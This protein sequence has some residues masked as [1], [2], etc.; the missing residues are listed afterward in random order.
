MATMIDRYVWAVVRLLP[1]AQRDEVDRELRSHIGEMVD[2]RLSDGADPNDPNDPADGVDGT[3]GSDTAGTD[4]EGDVDRASAAERAA[5]VDLGDPARLAVGYA[6][7][8][9]GLIA[10]ENFPQYM[11]SLRTIGI[12]AVP[13][14]TALATLGAALERDA[15]LGSVV[16]AA[17]SGA[18][19]SVVQVAFWVTLV[20]AFADRWRTPW[21]I[22]DLPEPPEHTASSAAVGMGE[23]I[24]G[25]VFTIFAGIALV[26]QHVDPP[27][28][29][30][31]G[32][33]VPVL[34]PGLWDGSA[35]ALLA[36]L[37]AS[38]AVQVVVLAS[39]RW[40]T[41]LAWMN[42]GVNAAFL[43]VVA[44]AALDE[45]LLNPRFFELLLEE[46]HTE[47]LITVSPWVP[48]VVVGA[49][50]VWDA[51]EAFWRARP[52]SAPVPTLV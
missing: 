47:T 15:D 25:V 3:Q 14:I 4:R 23:G 48:I 34:H 35:Q 8:P 28:D 36:I 11:R 2:A 46:G 39:R 21:S 51:A 50:E 42:A 33:G 20:W 9:R 10:P 44:W 38:V 19:S 24:F 31:A 18:F 27:M 52:R 22:D 13:A 40:T 26:W 29:D 32:R 45:R 17:I 37:A 12:I 7:E 43:A 6:A 5:L 49:I 41:G 1:E 30:A 16:G